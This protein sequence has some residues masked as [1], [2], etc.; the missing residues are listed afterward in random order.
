MSPHVFSNG[1][2]L[3]LTCQH[4]RRHLYSGQRQR[5]TGGAEG[6][7]VVAA[8]S[9]VESLTGDDAALKTSRLH[10]GI[11]HFQGLESNFSV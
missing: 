10:P 6:Y 5:A 2:K 8:L 3:N 7:Q 9:V 11:S 1:R 4:P